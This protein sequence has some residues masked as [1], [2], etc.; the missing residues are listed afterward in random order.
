MLQFKTVT[1]EDRA[2]MHE[3]LFAAGRT[4]CEYS[5]ANI[6]FWM[7]RHSEVA[8]VGDFVCIRTCYGGKCTYFYPAGKGDVFPVLEAM[9]RDAE[10]I[11]APFLLRS[12]TEEDKAILEALYPKQFDFTPLRDYFDYTYPTEKLTNLAGKKLQAKRNHINRFMDEHPD[13]HTEPLT[14]ANLPAVKDMMET[15]YAAREDA[16]SLMTERAALETALEYRDYLQMD[17]LVLWAE[18]KVMG[19]SMGNR[20]NET[21]FDVNFE[22]AFGEIQGAYPLINREFSRYIAEKYPEIALL[23]REDDMG[24]EGLRKAKESYYPDLL[25]KYQAAWRENA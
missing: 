20:L 7:R 19:F 2:W 12:V 25:V 23:N 24:L 8:R 21:V 13:W 4:G 17:G 11:G 16:R 1:M 10:F 14:E 3:L 18:G 9:R 6:Y 15:W 22:K 5:F